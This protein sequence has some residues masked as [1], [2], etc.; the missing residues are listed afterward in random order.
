MLIVLRTTIILPDIPRVRLP[1]I[2]L[3]ATMSL[4]ADLRGQTTDSLRTS[5]RPSATIDT[6]LVI[7]NRKTK[8]FVILN[9][10]TL[11]PGMTVTPEA[12]EFD[13]GR[14][15]SL[16]LFTRVDM[17]FQRV[18]SAGFL[19]VDV[20]ERWY[21]IPIP[22]LGF[23]DG[24]TKRIFYGAGLL[25]NNF[26]GVNQKLYGSFTLGFDPSANFQF[27]DPFLD[28]DEQIYFGIALGTSKIRNR[29]AAEAALTGDFDERHYDVN[30]LLG[31]RFDLYER[32]GIRVGYSVV[33]VSNYRQGRT[34][35]PSGRDGF[36]YCTL[37]RTY[38]SRDLSEYASSGAFNAVSITKNGIGE[39]ELNYWRLAADFRHYFPL[40]AGLTLAVRG[41]GSVVWGG[42]LPTYAH[43]YIGYTDRIRGYYSEVF[44]GEDIAGGTVELR[45]E[46]F[47]ARTINMTALPIPEEFAIWRFGVSLALF[48]DAGTTWRRADDLKLGSFYP[49]Y[50]IG[51]H[52]LLPY[53]YVG[54]VEYAR[55][56]NGQ[57]EF[58]FDLRG[59]I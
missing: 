12:M 22:I 11:R 6:I 59:S 28:R 16:G 43:T 45:I 20:N 17:E 24:D 42:E 26:R 58:I 38:D 7:G 21:I 32:A 47:K 27:Y 29:S 8:E 53:G 50:G 35:S 15:Y 36:M 34:A 54:R 46:L 3:V 49:G 9:E 23:R 30:V 51:L 33:Q 40:A 55:N 57:G 48:G 10:M 18:D 39:A 56:G 37:D 2:L 1:L 41:Y 19:I 14:I 44:E 31:K 13:R 4:L 52:F 25:H 5:E